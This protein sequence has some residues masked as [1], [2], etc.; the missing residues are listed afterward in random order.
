MFVCAGGLFGKIIVYSFILYGCSKII[1]K[2]IIIALF[3][4]QSTKIIIYC[5]PLLY[6]V[7][8]EICYNAAFRFNNSN[9]N[10]I[11][12]KHIANEKLFCPQFFVE[13]N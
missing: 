5:F 9:E 3:P 7:A 10:S 13:R 2:M 8:E 1:F 12:I 6:D 11:A 4:E